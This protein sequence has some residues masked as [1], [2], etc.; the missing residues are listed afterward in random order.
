MTNHSQIVGAM[1]TLAAGTFALRLTGPLLRTRISVPP[2]AEQVL[3]SSAVVLLTALLVTATLFDGHTY[4]GLA[5]P[6]GVLTAGV[7]AWRKAPFLAVILAAAS[8]TAL[9]R[10]LSVP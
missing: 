2:R 8:T 9:L 4:A 7:L 6:A 3:E 1:L 10:L 5:R